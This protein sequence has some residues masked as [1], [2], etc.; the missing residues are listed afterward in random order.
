MNK[1][2][3]LIEI[4]TEE[5]P[6]LKLLSFQTAWRTSFEQSLKSAQLEFSEIQTFVTPRRLAILIHELS[7]TQPDQ[8]IERK[9]PHLA[10]AFDAQGN[11]TPAT[12]GFLRGLNVTL[13]DCH[14]QETPKGTFLYY[15]ATQP[16]QT[17]DQ[18]IQGIVEQAIQAL[19]IPKPMRWNN[20]PY[21]FVRPVHWLVALHGRHILPLSLFGQTA[22]RY[23]HGHRFH[24]PDPILLR[25][26]S[27]YEAALYE[28][29]V[30]ADHQKRQA[31]IV[32]QSHAI[33]SMFVAT[34]VIDPSVLEEV[35]GLVEWPVALSASFD[36]TF[37]NLP[38]EIP[39]CS[40][41]THQ[42][43]FPLEN[44]EGALIEHFIVI[45]N[46]EST[47]PEV[48]KQGNERVVR[49]RLSDAAYFY[50]Q[51]CK[52]PLERRFDKLSQVVFQNQLGDYQ[53]K[54][55]RV[56]AIATTL[57]AQCSAN[58]EI[59]KRAS[60]LA[61]CDLLTQ[62]VHE[63]PELQGTMGYY[64]ALHQQ[65]PIEI[66]TAIA[67]HYK[68]RFA[69]DHLPTS[70]SGVLLALADRLDTITGIFG[71]GLLPT[72]TKDPYA[73]RRQAI[74]IIR[75]CVEKQLDLKLSELIT[76][77]VKQ[78]GA[79]LKAE[80]L[81]K[82]LPFFQERLKVWLQETY[83]ISPDLID[84]VMAVQPDHP[85]NILHRIEALSRFKHRPEAIHLA[86]AHKRVHNIL[87]KNPAPDHST[88]NPSLFESTAEKNLYEHLQKC[89]LVHVSYTQT[90]EQLA[91]LQQPV[92]DFFTEVMVIAEDL[93]IRHNRL[94]LLKQ[95]EHLFG[96]VADL[97]LLQS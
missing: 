79:L 39:I 57:A 87:A 37:L 86:A 46:I 80:H 21:H 12:Q 49:A 97:A 92:D 68:P 61:K 34:A 2:P 74:A 59:V 3:L 91:T 58:I 31:S 5:M 78:Y 41:Q 67:E 70:I 24:Y 23:T 71:I 64:Y 35:T 82:L 17:L 94:A 8:V 10:T 25:D 77:A 90:L 83:S 29:F 95:L 73:L 36:P 62:M 51:D 50:E 96:R 63:F 55:N 15:R 13:A 69:A 88:V 20:H 26:A 30:I 27:E 7:D 22:D 9:G 32:S 89:D 38:K 60:H 42:R 47:L 54:T 66:A 16:G 53:S 1:A 76:L 40:M 33:A 44:A 18:L 43:Y 72:G 52:Q 48:I 14:H 93:K 4:G 56:M 65:E 19:P 75:L 85:L 81:S 28:R 11:P 84:A 6:P 45:S